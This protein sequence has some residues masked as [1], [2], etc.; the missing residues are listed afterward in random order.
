MQYCNIFENIAEPGS[1]FADKYSDFHNELSK[2]SKVDEKLFN[3]VY[4]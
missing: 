2:N 3:K 1:N 4:K